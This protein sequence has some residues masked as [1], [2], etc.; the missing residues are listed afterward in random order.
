L[1]IRC[2]SVFRS[3]AAA[4]WVVQRRPAAKSDP[5][6]FHLCA[7]A[8]RSFD[9]KFTPKQRVWRFIHSIVRFE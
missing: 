6:K 9:A 5:E 7:K 3:R 1:A 2:G 4:R 8:V